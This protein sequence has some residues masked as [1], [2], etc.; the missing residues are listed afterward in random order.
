[1]LITEVLRND[2]DCTLS[3][4][5]EGHA[6]EAGSVECAAASILACTVAQIVEASYRH[7]DLLYPPTVKLENGEAHIKCMCCREEYGE[8]ARAFFFAHTGF[9]LLAFKYPDKV[10]VNPFEDNGE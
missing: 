10:S 2:K 5:C 7:G 4:T 1:M 9:H 6:G 3:L 8:L